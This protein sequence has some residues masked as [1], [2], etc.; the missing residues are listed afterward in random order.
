VALLR[1]LRAL[2]AGVDRA[3][4]CPPGGPFAAELAEQGFEHLSI[5]GTGVSFRLHPLWTAVGF[6]ELARSV[7]AL[8]AHV[9]RWRPDVIHANGTRAGLLAAPSGANALISQVH[10]IMPP[11]RV[12]KT[13]RGILTRASDRVVAVSDAAT[14]AFNDGMRG[15][16]ARTVYISIDHGRFRPDGHDHAATRRSLGVP[17][18]APLLGQVAQ[19]TPWKGQMTSIDA[20]ALVRR[21]HPDAHLALVGQV[22]FSGPSVRYDNAAYNRQLHARVEK[23]GLQDAVHFTGFRRDVEHVMAACDLFLLPSWKEPFGTVVVE[24]MA[25]GTVPMVAEGGGVSEFVEDGVSGRVLEPMVAEPWGRAAIELLD[26]PDRRERMSAA[27][28]EVASHFTDEAYAGTM[29][30]LYTAL[31]R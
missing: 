27:A 29:M 19:I 12:S 15:L 23:L 25:S 8:R 24:A 10:D 17:E 31:A 22:A 2:P 14:D 13:V 11:G 5:P 3:V 7:A 6:S 28:V 18:G 20:L 21:K 16:P 26:D 9:R 4:A 30:G 1:L